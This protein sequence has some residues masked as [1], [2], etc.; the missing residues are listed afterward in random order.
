MAKLLKKLSKTAG[1]IP[2]DLVHVGERKIDKVK[3]SVIDY[4]SVNFQEKEVKSIE[5]VFPFKDTPTVTWVNID[6]LHD[7]EIITKL[8][9][10]FEMHPLTMEDIV[11][12][13]QRPK[14]EDFDKYIFVVLKMFMFKEK[15]KEVVSE[16]VSL[17]FGNNFVISLQ[18]KEGD[19]FNPIRERIRKAKGRIR[20]MGADYLAYS[21][22]DSVVDNYF[23]ILEKIGEKIEEM[24]EKIIANPVPKT[25][26]MI[27]R[28]KQ[29]II[30]LR[31]SVW[32]LREVVNA[33][34]R[35]ESKLIA[36][37]TRIFLRDLYDHTIQVIDTVETYRDMVS[38]MLDIYMS[39]VSNKMNEVMKVLT[40]IATIF[41]PITFVAG[42]YGMNFDPKISP[43]NM[44]ELSWKFG[45][46]GAWGIM[47]LIALTMLIYFR[48]KKWI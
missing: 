16:Q 42:I 47:I 29:D 23:S 6:G 21:L 3:I 24:E 46:F 5:E 33:L 32:P 20:K 34:E 9:E 11:N 45:Y 48:R 38:G 31:K 1:H 22:L 19:V 2:G 18:E 44:P 28:S 15:S 37:P 10:R 30:F 13:G 36:K 40:I 39:G 17:I 7:T 12:T 35:S 41:I 43:W 25:L 4:D 27:H 26:Q 8:G 14:Y